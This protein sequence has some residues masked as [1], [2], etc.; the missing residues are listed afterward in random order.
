MRDRL[1]HI[2]AQRTIGLA[3]VGAGFVLAILGIVRIAFSKL[4]RRFVGESDENTIY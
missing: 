3:T 1:H 2:E 4:E